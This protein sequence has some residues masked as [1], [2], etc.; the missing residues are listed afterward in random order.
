VSNK[1]KEIKET[2]AKIDELNK[3]REKLLAE[4]KALVEVIE[5]C[6]T[7]VSDYDKKIPGLM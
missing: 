7:T 2:L 3:L 5:A 1:D 6:K 4:L